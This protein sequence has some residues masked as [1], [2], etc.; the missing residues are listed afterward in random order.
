MIVNRNFL[1]KIYVILTNVLDELFLVKDVHLLS[2]WRFDEQF[3]LWYH[4][5]QF[6]STNV[7]MTKLFLGLLQYHQFLEI[8]TITT[9]RMKN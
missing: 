8:G 2:F 1:L 5:F 6:L 7:Y 3:P 9:K 4:L